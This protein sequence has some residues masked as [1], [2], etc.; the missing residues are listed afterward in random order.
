MSSAIAPA[1]PQLGKRR[2]PAGFADSGSDD[3]DGGAAVR[4]LIHDVRADQK[5]RAPRTISG[6][7]L[8]TLFRMLW[9]TRRLLGL[10]VSTRLPPPHVAIL[11]RSLSLSL[12]ITQSRA[13]PRGLDAA[14]LVRGTTDGADNVAAR[15]LGPD[16]AAPGDA[17]KSEFGRGF[18]AQTGVED[19]EDPLL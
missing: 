11:G 15:A 13:R 19:G 14:A 18:T 2:R 17:S 10:V 16:A 4:S 7:C 12:S 8:P 6:A 3:G 1:A 9:P 5:V